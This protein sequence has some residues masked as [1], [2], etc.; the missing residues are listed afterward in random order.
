MALKRLKTG[1]M[2][3]LSLPWITENS[4]ARNAILAVPLLAA[5]LPKIEAAH[6]ALHSTQ[7]GA[8]DSRLAKVQEK[9]AGLDLRHDEIVRGIYWLPT[10][11]AWLV[12]AGDSA[13]SLLRL[14]DLL[15]PNGLDTA[16]KSYREE[17]GATALLKTRLTTDAP[18]KKMVKD[19]PVMKQSLSHFIDELVTI[20]KKL[21][22][23]EDERAKLLTSTPTV[24]N[25]EAVTARNKWIRAVNALVANAELADLPEETWGVIFG[26]LQV[27]EK[28]ADK[29]RGPV[30]DIPEEAG[31]PA[32]EPMPAA[33]PKK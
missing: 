11:L 1:E 15:L 17:A 25:A 4:E 31:T 30:L 24:D 20:G 12:G 26:P 13:E 8:A 6:Q 10:A 28:A 2:V 22:E 23:A 27:A 19:I 29:R 32:P 18:A 33:P 14:R 21:G 9:A 16:Q 5:I 7:P 3:Q